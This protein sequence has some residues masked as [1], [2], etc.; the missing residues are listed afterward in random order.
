MDH[1]S[2]SAFGLLLLCAAGTAFSAEAQAQTQPHMMSASSASSAKQGVKTYSPRYWYVGGEFFSP[3]LFDDLYSWT[4]QDFSLG[5]GVNFRVGYQFSSVFGLE[6]NLGLGQNHLYS[7]PFQKDFILGSYDAYTYYPYTMLNGTKYEYKH[8]GLVGEQGNNPDKVSVEGVAFPKLRS[9]ARFW[10]ASLNASFNLTR[11]LYAS[12]YREKPIELWLKPGAYLSKFDTEVQNVE[13][14]KSAAPRVNQELTW[15]LGGDVSLRFNLTSRWA[16]DVSNRLIWQ[17]DH[18]MD[19]VLNIKKAYDSY[20]WQPGV[21]LTYK[22]RKVQTPKLASPV[23]PVSMEHRPSLPALSFWYPEKVELPQRKQRTHS[24]SIYLT[25]VLN[26]TE[27][28]PQLH[29]NPR[30]LARLERDIKGYLT[31]PDYKVNSIKIEGFASPEG[32][33]AN[34]LRLASGR[35]ASIIQYIARR[36]QTDVSLFQVGRMSENWA[37]LRDTLQRNPSLPG[38]DK[39]LSLLAT[40]PDTEELKAKLRREPEYKALLSE[41]YPYLRLSTYTVDYDVKSY[42]RPSAQEQLKRQPELLS[43]E[44]IYSVALGY[45]LGTPQADEAIA[46]LEKLYPSSDLMRSYRGI[47]LLQEGHRSAAIAQLESVH[48]KDAAVWNALGVAYAQDGQL[49]KAKQLLRVAASTN[50]DA[51]K[52]LGLLSRLSAR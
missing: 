33:Y 39:F 16:L 25:Y 17:H 43:A 29:D 24:D 18:S 52:N 46:V 47:T 19:G 9:E 1:F 32:P 42:D 4:S 13:T 36:S 40:T 45:G 23:F 38:R 6:A 30:E 27:I 15:G 48:D 12:E 51:R 2:H 35:A 31:H 20:V 8:G 5:K 22:F 7:S 41:V 49:E 14:G 10:Q 37:G 11:L 28:A 26:R 21:G 3:L 44:E 50:S 34:N